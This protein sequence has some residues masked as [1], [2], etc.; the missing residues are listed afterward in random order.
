MQMI[1]L[2]VDSLAGT[3]P[4][5]MH[6]PALWEASVSS[7]NSVSQ[8]SLLCGKNLPFA[9]IDVRGVLY[10]FATPVPITAVAPQDW[11]I[12]F[13]FLSPGHTQLLWTAKNLF[14]V[15]RGWGTR[16]VAMSFHAVKSLEV[17]ENHRIKEG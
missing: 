17:Q 5:V 14:F 8:I 6:F 10:P 7:T 15:G 4:S 9:K 3:Q 1:R 13:G 11:H 16:A 2:P 12:S